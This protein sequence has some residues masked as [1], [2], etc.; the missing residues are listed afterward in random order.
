M[1]EEKDHAEAASGDVLAIFLSMAVKVSLEYCG[2]VLSHF[3]SILYHIHIIDLVWIL[4]SVPIHI[5]WR[6][7]IEQCYL[8][9][10]AAHLIL[11]NAP[12]RVLWWVHRS[13]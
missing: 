2:G 3:P 5:C 10:P 8:P 6:N 13:S 12:G 11:P 1:K 9:A 7:T 4:A